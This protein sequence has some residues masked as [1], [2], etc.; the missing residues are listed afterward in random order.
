MHLR[1]KM[2]SEKHWKV[3]A[4][5]ESFFV[6]CALQ[7]RLTKRPQV[8]QCSTTLGHRGDSP[9]FEYMHSKDPIMGGGVRL[10]KT[11]YLNGKDSGA[12]QADVLVRARGS[13]IICW[14]N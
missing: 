6:A 1:Y 10:H 14:A 9:W 5:S 4:S 3:L 2:W 7:V 8:P 12:F 11:I 13:H